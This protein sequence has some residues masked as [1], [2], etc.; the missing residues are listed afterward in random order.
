MN[1]SVVIVAA[2]KSLR[3]GVNKIF[4]KLNDKPMIIHTLE[5]Y[6]ENP[7]IDEIMLVIRK[8]DEEK[9]K[10]LLEEY[11]IKARLVYGGDHRQE[12]SY[13][14]IMQAKGGII[15]IHDCARPL[16]CQDTIDKVIQSANETG[17]AISA[18]RVKDTIKISENGLVRKT[19]DRKDLWQVQT[20]QAFRSDLIRQA[21][22]EAIKDKFTG[23]DDAVLVERSGKKIA[24]VNSDYEN[25]KIT[26]PDDIKFAEII[27]KRR[28]NNGV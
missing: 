9:I 20:P 6:K 12:S 21:H 22:E 14:G 2:G 28:K 3:M 4:L 23:T 15:L 8:K 24:I 17:A 26:T 10:D 27:I 25:I 5:A 11:D 16:V 19:I 7:N 13:N 18:V 1:N